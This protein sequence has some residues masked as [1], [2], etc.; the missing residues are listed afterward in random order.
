MSERALII[1]YRSECWTFSQSDEQNWTCLRGKYCESYDP[2]KDGDTWG[3]R[4]NVELFALYKE[5]KLTTAIRIARLC[6]LAT[7]NTWKMSRC[8]S[9]SY[10]QKPVGEGM[11]EG[12]DQDDWTKLTQMLGEWE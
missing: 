5:P 9:N 7:C 11:W 12:Q 3:S 2:I 1:M 10:M 6:G 4:S 8:P